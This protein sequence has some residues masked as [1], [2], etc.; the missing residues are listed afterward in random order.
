VRLIDAISS[1][2]R[3][4]AMCLVQFPSLCVPQLHHWML[5]RVGM[6]EVTYFNLQCGQWSSDW[7][8]YAQ[9]NQS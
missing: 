7:M 8:G 1:G 3:I 9:I 6:E 4:E 2:S 5:T